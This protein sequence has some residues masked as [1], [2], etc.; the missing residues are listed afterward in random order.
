MG[1]LIFLLIVAGIAYR[2]A[3][4]EERMRFFQVVLTYVRQAKDTAVSHGQ[5]EC[6]PFRE[7]LRTRTRWVVVTPA[8]V[9]LNV[10]VFVCMIFGAGAL[11]DPE[12]IVGWGGN[13]GPRTT[14]GEWWRLVTA[15][16]VH[17]GMLHLI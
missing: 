7:G 4:P 16:F 14:N 9:A 11:G 1:L 15:M 13:L 2:T 8:L 5:S 12:T 17:A 10:M 6:E 3:T